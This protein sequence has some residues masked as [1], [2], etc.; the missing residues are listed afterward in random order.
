MWDRLCP[1]PVP[2]PQPS[3]GPGDVGGDGPGNGSGDGVGAGP[4]MAGGR[5]RERPSHGSGGG[6]AA[7]NGGDGSGNGAG[8]GRGTAVGAELRRLWGCWRGRGN[9]PAVP[10]PRPGD[11]GWVSER[12]GRAVVGPAAPRPGRRAAAAPH[13]A[14]DG[15]GDGAGMAPGAVGTLVGTAV[16]VVSGPAPGMAGDVGGNGRR[17][18]PGRRERCRERPSHGSGR[19]ERWRRQWGH[20]RGGNGAGDGGGR[21]RG[22]R[23]GQLWGRLRGCWRE[24][25]RGCLRAVFGVVETDRLFQIA[26]PVSVVDQ[27]GRPQPRGVRVLIGG[28][29]RLRPA[30]SVRAVGSTKQAGRFCID[31]PPGLFFTV[32]VLSSTRPRTGRRPWTSLYWALWTSPRW[33][34]R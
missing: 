8:D 20:R 33:G 22:H 9:R 23:R 28:V 26:A 3:H 10:D 24:R 2:G 14:G 27:G 16:G 29:E 25:R 13:G 5:R 15:A 21:P 4:G 34:S 17:T 32:G 19:R 1:G 6:N 12:W 30:G 11:P 18:V 7:G 31:K